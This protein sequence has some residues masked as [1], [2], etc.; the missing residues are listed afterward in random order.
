[1]LVRNRKARGRSQNGRPH[2]GWPG[3]GPAEGVMELEE[4]GKK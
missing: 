4:G 1:M 3:L 2:H